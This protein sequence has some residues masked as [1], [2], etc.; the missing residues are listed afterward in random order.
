MRKTLAISPAVLVLVLALPTTHPTLAPE[1][2]WAPGSGPGAGLATRVDG[3][4]PHASP[5]VGPGPHEAAGRTRGTE[6]GPA[7]E[8]NG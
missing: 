5:E 6:L 8:P 7:M 4:D 1:P 3:T 2:S